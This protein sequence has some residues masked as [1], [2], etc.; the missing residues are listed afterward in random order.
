MNTYFE[1]SLVVDHYA[2]PVED[3]SVREHAEDDSADISGGNF[4]RAVFQGWAA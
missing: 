4:R 2:R 1:R 3:L